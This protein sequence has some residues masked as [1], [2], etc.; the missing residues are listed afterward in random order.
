MPFFRNYN[1]PT[2]LGYLFTDN[3]KVS[4]CSSWNVVLFTVS[5]VVTIRPTSKHMEDLAVD[6]TIALLPRCPL[7]TIANATPA[8]SVLLAGI[9][10][11]L[12]WTKI[13]K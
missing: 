12:C 1:I 7:P 3:R 10:T 13:L 6:T 8:T 2:D 5:M 9:I 4:S 11:M